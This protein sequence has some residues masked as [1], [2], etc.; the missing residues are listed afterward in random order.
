MLEAIGNN[1]TNISKISKK[2]LNESKSTNINDMLNEAHN[3]GVVDLKKSNGKL[4][5]NKHLHH[6]FY[7]RPG[8]LR[9][10]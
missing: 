9:N 5:E 1:I 3:I 10:R 8:G 6:I 4:I 2:K 7:H